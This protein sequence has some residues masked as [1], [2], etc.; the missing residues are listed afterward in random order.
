MM[1]KKIR[2]NFRI[3]L[4]ILCLLTILI[5]LSIVG[6]AQVKPDRQPSFSFV[7]M[8]DLHTQP[9]L[10]ATEGVLQA[11]DSVNQL[12]PDFVVTGGDMIMDALGQGF[13]RADSLY[14]LAENLFKRL[15]MP[16]YTSLGNHEVFGLYVRIGIDS[17]HALYGK[18][19]YEKYFGK[20]YYSFDFKTWHFI[21]LDG[22]GFTPERRYFGVIDSAQINWLKHD[23]LKTGTE[24][25]VAIVTH[26]PLLSTGAQILVSPTTAFSQSE[27]VTN[28]HEVFKIIEPYN[29]KLVLQGHLHYLED[30]YYNGTHFITG[31]AVCS[32]WWK[33]KRYG[34]EE[35]FLKIDV[36]GENFTWRYVDFKWEPENAK[37]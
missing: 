21:V 4:P 27:I 12:R 23:L 9:E 8:T 13:G 34:M 29:V 17:T 7:F 11:I 6:R 33:G 37:P 36:S 31:G 30:N 35:G 1:V 10:N 32:D 25:P 15:K 3:P 26:I 19:M 2:T 22:I 28:S 14:R 20:T 16:V 18:K 5:I 24:K